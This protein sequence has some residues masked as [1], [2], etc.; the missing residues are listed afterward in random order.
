[1]NLVILTRKLGGVVGGV[2]KMVLLLAKEMQLR[3]HVVTVVSLDNLVAEAFYDWPVG[4]S[5]VKLGIGDVDSTA[6]FRV[7]IKRILAIRKLLRDQQIDSIVGFQIGSFVLARL[8]SVFS[9]I[10]CVAAE[11]NAPT[12]FEFIKNGRMKRFFSSLALFSAD[13][14]SV[15]LEEN[16]G[17]YPSLLQNKILIN[18][19]AILVPKNLRGPKISQNPKVILYVGR[20][21]FQKNIE[22]LVNAVSKL[23]SPTIL[24]IVGS[25]DSLQ[26]V[27]LLAKSLHVNLELCEF[28]NTL[29]HHYLSADVFCLPSR[30]EGFPNVV[31]EALSYGLPVVGFKDCAGM[32]SLVVH[33]KTG[34]VAE[35]NN[36]PKSLALALDVALATTWDPTQIRESTKRFSL[37]NF[38]KS[39][40]ATLS[41]KGLN[42]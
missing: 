22:V 8:A 20:V 34:I 32:K 10:K 4:V 30:W 26:T 2:E 39:W 25:G 37:E 15:Q 12:L 9:G 14:I 24:R 13:A 33:G 19:N 23:G 41:P 28:S 27:T 3:G 38:I 1:M 42:G 5:W 17:L 40:E 18:H 21:T 7:R 29:E 16:R 36:D 11:R 35:G 6:T 31:G